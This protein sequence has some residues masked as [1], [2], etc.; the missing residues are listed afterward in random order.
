[1]A[2]F[3]VPI[4]QDELKMSKRLM[5]AVLVDKKLQNLQELAINMTLTK[6]VPPRKNPEKKY[7]KNF[8][9]QKVIKVTNKKRFAADVI[10]FGNF[11]TEEQKLGRRVALGETGKHLLLQV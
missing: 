5:I 1:M 2:S 4:A 3:S 11:T 8:E 7:P 9:M 6:F 10:F